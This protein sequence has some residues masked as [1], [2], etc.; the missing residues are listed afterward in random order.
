[1]SPLWLETTNDLSSSVQNQPAKAYLNLGCGY[2]VH[3]AW[4]NVDFAATS[5]GVIAH[6]LIQGIPF[7]DASF[8]VVYHSHVLEHFSRSS[9]ITFLQECYRVLRPQGVIRVVVPDLEQITRTYLQALEQSIAGNSEWNP[10]YDWMLLELL[11]QVARHQSGGEMYSHLA[12][13]KLKDPEFIVQRCGTEIKNLIESRATSPQVTPPVSRTRRIL[14]QVYRFLNHASSRREAVLKFILGSEYTAL[15]IGRFRQSGEVH[16]WMY[17]RHSLDRL[18]QHSGF[19]S[20]VQRS[21]TESYIPDWCSYQ[22]DTEHDGSVYK[23]DS[24]FMEAI[25]LA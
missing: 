1:M 8:D 11:D 24:L 18:L 20:I 10:R 14:R 19:S 12:Q 6:N 7:P 25:K 2:R 13:S 15:Q 21:A 4:I 9:A 16:Q 22:L 17:D 3:S 5:E 23:P